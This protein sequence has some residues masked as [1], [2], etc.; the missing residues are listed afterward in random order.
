MSILGFAGRPTTDVLPIWWI[1]SSISPIRSETFPA[2]TAR[3]TPDRKGQPLLRSFVHHGSIYGCTV[4]DSQTAR[5]CATPSFTRGE[6]R[7]GCQRTVRTGRW[8]LPRE[9]RIGDTS[10]RPVRRFLPANSFRYGLVG[11]VCDCTPA[12]AAS[13]CGGEP[14]R[15]PR[16]R[17]LPSF[18]R[19][20][21]RSRSLPRLAVYPTAGRIQYAIAGPDGENPMR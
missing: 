10:Q 4:P 1:S 7:R 18:P 8:K 13:A 17:G 19:T 16:F 21:R 2:R 3:A 14:S 15:E 11:P 5:K 9:N 20:R 12:A 6:N